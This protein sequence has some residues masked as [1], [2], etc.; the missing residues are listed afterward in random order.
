MSKLKFISDPRA[1]RALTWMAAD[2]TKLCESSCEQTFA[3]A[4][5]EAPNAE[6]EL[7]PGSVLADVAVCFLGAAYSVLAGRFGVGFADRTLIRVVTSIRLAQEREPGLGV[8][9]G[10]LLFGKQP[11]GKA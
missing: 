2:L 9:A 6:G 3:E 5:A 8:D 10:V 4:E 11:I 7:L 1:I